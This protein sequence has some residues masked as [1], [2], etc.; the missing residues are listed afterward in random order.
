MASC[1]SGLMP[2]GSS[3][4]RTHTWCPCFCCNERLLAY[5]QLHCRP[6]C[7]IL[8]WHTSHLLRFLQMGPFLIAPQSGKPDL[9][10]AQS[11][12]PSAVCAASFPCQAVPAVC[13]NIGHCQKQVCL[14]EV[15]LC[16]NLM[17][18]VLAEH[19][20][21]R[22]AWFAFHPKCS[23]F[24]CVFHELAISIYSSCLH[25]QGFSLKQM[26]QLRVMLCTILS[27]QDC[28]LSG[29][30]SARPILLSI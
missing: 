7:W 9:P 4:R 16:T 8:D 29:L 14:L 3:N 19:S 6:R 21:K 28:L 18:R 25:R 13:T 15:V 20:A 27:A 17:C 1:P 11:A 5:L 26:F 2:Y 12:P 22:E 24:C 23:A 10:S 30:Q